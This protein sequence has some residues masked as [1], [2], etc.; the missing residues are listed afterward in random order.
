MAESPEDVAKRSVALI[1]QAGVEEAEK[2]INDCQEKSPVLDCALCFVRTVKC[3]LTWDA[4]VMDQADTFIKG[5][6]QRCVSAA[7]AA[8]GLEQALQ[9]KI[10]AADC[11]LL[12]ALIC[13]AK[14]SVAQYV[15]G[16]V[17]LRSASKIY[18][19]V[20]SDMLRL[21]PDHDRVAAANSM[22]FGV[23]NVAISLLPEKVLSL[24]KIV[25]FQ[26][27][28]NVG[29]KS[30]DIVLHSSDLRAPFAMLLVLAY[31]VVVRPVLGID[32]KDG[33]SGPIEAANGI[34][35]LSQSVVPDAPLFEY[36]RGRVAFL[37]KDT[38]K[39]FEC[40]SSASE[41]SAVQPEL[42]Q[43]CK[44][45]I[46]F[47]RILH[48]EWQEVADLLNELCSNSPWSPG[49]YTFFS[50]VAY[51]AIGNAGEAKKRFS[52]VPD[53]IKQKSSTLETLVLQKVNVFTKKPLTAHS[54]QIEMLLFAYLSNYLHWC[55]P[56]EC[57]A[58]IEFVEE[59][60]D[61]VSTDPYFAAASALVAGSA[62][63][64][65]GDAEKAEPH[66]RR[67]LAHAKTCVDSGDSYIPAHATLQLAK[68]YE[69]RGEIAKAR[70][71]LEKTKSL[72]SSYEL[73]GQVQVK[74]KA[75]LEN[76]P[77]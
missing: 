16:G 65:M 73:E 77:N 1:F 45:E 14:Q 70:N 31:N 27:D 57:Q 64:Q 3:L 51:A 33:L 22:G 37:S 44:Y 42:Q 24:M 19:S 43:L 68:V 20:Q 30:L 26:G 67:V 35:E 58:V 66:L 72:Y 75:C 54:A 40:F 10:I 6:E 21:K 17:L 61:K 50:A 7:K 8:D 52:A 4:A 29:L 56:D 32:V 23:V 11:D 39:A 74:V 49:I 55:S 62:S 60:E 18:T 69:L 9:L 5:V 71:A 41:R 36:F 12:R 76:L 47:I 46:N 63:V 2:A 53:L 25:G 13:F 48:L 38:A 15:K 28:R 34:L 59:T